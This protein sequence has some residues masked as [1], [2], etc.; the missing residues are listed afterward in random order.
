MK[1]VFVHHTVKHFFVFGIS[2]ISVP[3]EYRHLA[4]IHCRTLRT[5]TAN[6]TANRR[7]ADKNRANQMAQKIKFFRSQ[8]ICMEFD[9]SLAVKISK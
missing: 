8:N 6:P 2:E 3:G 7:N 4:Q 1:Y 9:V 5:L